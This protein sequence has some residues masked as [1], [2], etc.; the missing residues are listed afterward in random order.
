MF[1]LSGDHS[2]GVRL[3]QLERKIDLILAHLG[4]DAPPGGLSDRVRQLMADGRKIEAIKVYREQTGVGLKE[5]KDV[6][7][8]YVEGGA[9]PEV[10]PAARVPGDWQATAR[11]GNLIQA[12]KEYREQTG[13]GLKEAKGAVDAYLREEKGR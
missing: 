7:D 6:V 13:A 9:V 4:I 11:S 3:A 5:A 12:I 8:A 2:Q 1:G 10:G